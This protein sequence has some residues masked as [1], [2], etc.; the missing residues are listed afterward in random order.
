MIISNSHSQVQL[1]SERV[2]KVQLGSKSL[3]VQPVN[4]YSVQ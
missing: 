3:G 1:G 4:E 2:L